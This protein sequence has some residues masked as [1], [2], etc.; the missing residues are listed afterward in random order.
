M[1]VASSSAADCN[2]PPPKKTLTECRALCL[3]VADN[4]FCEILLVFYKKL[5]VS[6]QTGAR[7]VKM[8]G[9]I[10]LVWV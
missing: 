5:S 10:S 6:C 9:D 8:K 3:A 1:M 4:I 2:H 7:T